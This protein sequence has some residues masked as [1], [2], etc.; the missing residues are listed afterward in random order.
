[1]LKVSGVSIHNTDCMKFFSKIPNQCIDLILTDP[2]YNISKFSS[3]NISL[4]NRK[5]IN[6][7]ISDWDKIE[8]DQ[9]RLSFEFLR[10]IK[11]T[12]NI[13]ISLVLGINYLSIRQR[14]FNIL[15][16]IK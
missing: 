2:P 6:N 1:M 10:I 7:D 9:E 4:P 3:G 15:F 8:I 12:G 11:P 13:F 16:G 14:H 5:P